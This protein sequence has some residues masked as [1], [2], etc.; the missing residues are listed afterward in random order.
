MGLVESRSILAQRFVNVSGPQRHAH[1]PITQGSSVE[2]GHCLE[3][4]DAF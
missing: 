1:P 4:D 3:D 2:K